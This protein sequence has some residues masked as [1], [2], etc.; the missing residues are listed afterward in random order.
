MLQVLYYNQVFRQV[1]LNSSEVRNKK[2]VEERGAAVPSR[3]LPE[4]GEKQKAEIDAI[5]Q[6]AHGLRTGQELDP[7][8]GSASGLPRVFHV[9]AQRHQR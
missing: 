4:H 6:E 2:D 3:P 7:G 5:H 1:V 9:V 8:G